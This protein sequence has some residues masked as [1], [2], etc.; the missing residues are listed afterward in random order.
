MCAHAL[1]ETARDAL[2]LSRIP[3]ERL[4]FVYIAVAAVALAIMGL[5]NRMARTWGGGAI[6]AWLLVTAAVTAG[7][8]PLVGDASVWSLYAL[9]VWSAVA[10]TVVLTR[11]FILLGTR[12]TVTQA[13]RLYTFIG[14]GTVA[15]AIAGSA[16]AGLLAAVMPAANLLLAAAGVLAVSALGPLLLDRADGQ[17]EAAPAAKASNDSMLAAAAQVVASPYARRV[18]LIVLLATVTF[19]FVDF[20][21]KREVA[22]GVKAKDLGFFFARV[23]LVLNVLSLVVQL[24]LVRP[25]L[26][27]LGIAGA[28]T[29]LPVLLLFGGAGVVVGGGIVAALALKGADGALRHSLYRTVTELLYVPMRDRLRAAAKMFIDV[30]GQRGGQALASLA[31]LGA[32]ALDMPT[33]FYGG[34]ILLFAGLWIGGAIAVRRQYFSL[35]RSTLAEAAERN[36]VDFPELD[37]SSLES[38]M[39]ALNSPNNAEVRAALQLMVEQGRVRIIPALILYHPSP[40][41]VADALEIFSHS[42]RDDFLHITDRLL[43]HEYAAVRAAALRSRISRR[44][45]EALLRRKV[46][47]TCPV[48]KA[49]ALV[50]LSGHGYAREGEADSY[51]EEIIT[52]GS[53]IAKEA[54]AHAVGFRPGPQFDDVLLRLAETPS[55]MVRQSVAR[56]MAAQPSDRYLP[57]LLGMLAERDLRGA[58][59][60]TLVKMGEPAFLYLAA[61]FEDETQPE[62]IRRHLPRTLTR[63]EPVRAAP[64]L[65]ARLAD[66]RDGVVRYKILRGLGRLVEDTPSLKLD[67]K[68]LH[69]MTERMVKRAYRLIDWRLSLERGVEET[70]AY[71][72]EAHRLL[73]KLLHDKEANAI[74]SLFRLLAL[75]YRH[76]NLATIYRGLRN[77]RSDVRSSSLELIEHTLDPPLRG[78]VLG[79]VDDADDG[80]RLGQAG[81]FHRRLDFSYHDLLAEL[82]ENAGDSLRGLAVYHILE[83]GLTDLR[84]RVVSDDA[85]KSGFLE[86]ILEEAVGI[87]AQPAPE[88]GR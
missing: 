51:F 14:A 82:L 69:L 32:V 31:I 64:V 25:V 56:S 84:S 11:F 5:Q 85:P 16:V 48:V 38:L 17:H 34:A 19:T 41:V 1:L 10:V 40:E 45:D 80:R 68:P 71:E 36:E 62:A 27:K 57:S 43:D 20:V 7:F 52:D 54:L 74:E 8:W 9:Y 59:R 42:D 67:E 4:P 37:V 26:R 60:D 76:A 70:P 29:I 78:A 49:T 53:D 55:A 12:F 23:Y 21:F 75:L 24:V 13:K 47:V 65:V 88:P 28:L 79:L 18:A 39:A 3:A 87:R 22:A 66:E 73:V 77:D 61:A 81:S 2:F 86:T 58:V 30:A 15:G 44:P 6:A 33:A 46:E 35:F 83:L 72:T 63:F 50:G